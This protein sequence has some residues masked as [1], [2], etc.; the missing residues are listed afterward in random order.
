VYEPLDILVEAVERAGYHDLVVYG[1]D[2]AASHFF[3]P[4]TRKYNIA[5]KNLSRDEMIQLYKDLTTKYSLVS[6]EDPLHEDDFE[7]WA[8]LTKEIKIQIVG[9]DLFVT[10]SARLLNGIKVGAA[11]ALLWK[12]N[13]IG[14]LT[15]ALD[16]A[17]IAFRNGYAV[18]VSERSG[19]T[20]DSII[21]DLSVALNCGQ[22]KT[23]APVRGERTS[24][25]NQLLRIEEELGNQAIYAGEHFRWNEDHM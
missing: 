6:I 15:E 25:Y 12:F 8:E 13:Q 10:N 20:E 18:Q 24:K 5:G 16:A 2:V 22:I 14:T 7:G 1:L 19:E 17:E 11:N 9:D 23:G 21:A 3:N 4:Q